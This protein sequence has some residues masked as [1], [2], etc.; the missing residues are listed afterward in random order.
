MSYDKL[1]PLIELEDYPF[2]FNIRIRGYDEND[3]YFSMKDLSKHLD[4]DIYQEMII[5][6][7]MLIEDVDYKIF[8]KQVFYLTYLG[9]LKVIFSTRKP[10]AESFARW[11]AKTLFTVQMGTRKA[12][13]ELAATIIG[14]T[15]KEVKAI[16]SKQGFPV[17]CVYLILIG[18]VKDLRTVMKIPS[19]YSDDAMVFKYGMTDDLLRRLTEHER[20]YG[21]IKNASIELC[22]YGIV[23]VQYIKQAENM[24]S[25]GF[26]LIKTK[27]DYDGHKELIVLK[28]AELKNIKK[29]FDD[30][31][32]CYCDKMANI[33]ALIKE[34]RHRSDMLQM[35]LDHE[36]EKAL[37]EKELLKKDNEILEM[38]YNQL[39]KDTDAKIASL[40]AQLAKAR[41]H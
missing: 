20:M 12:K 34:E 3:I 15:V 19:D 7:E 11:A 22:Y 6:N 10:L 21:K 14:S 8:R 29:T 1:P 13:Q 38:K 5:D 40:K 41:K 26:D 2:D 9:I 36:K 32:N 16:L 37:M 24:L 30:I 17:S 25:N 33:N 39:K 27:I 28:K 4:V 31:S 35:A 18:T 23:D